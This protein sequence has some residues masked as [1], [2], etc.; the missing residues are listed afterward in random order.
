MPTTLNHPVFRVHN[1][2]PLLRGLPVV[3]LFLAFL[4]AFVVTMRL[5][6]QGPQPGGEEGRQATSTPG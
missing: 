6:T 4:I 2:H 5:D 1:R 3:L